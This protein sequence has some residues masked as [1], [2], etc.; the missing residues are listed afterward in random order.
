VQVFLAKALKH[1]VSILARLLFAIPSS[2]LKRDEKNECSFS[3]PLSLPNEFSFELR[4]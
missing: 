4:E 2:L 3:L 1:F